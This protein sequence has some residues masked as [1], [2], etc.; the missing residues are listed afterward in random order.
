MKTV[1]PIKTIDREIKK[2]IQAVEQEIPPE[3][4]AAFLEKLN[5]TVPEIIHFRRRQ[6]IYYGALVTA[7]TVLL[8]ILLFLF[9]LFHRELN[10]I[11]AGEIWVQDAR[12][13]GHP[14]ST[15]VINPKDQAVTIVWLEKIN[16]KTEENN[17][18]N[19]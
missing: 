17:E 19:H 15:F 7:A 12:V 14:A 3:L 2:R 6:L 1:K 5:G 13:E 16:H 10:V 11:E 8:V 9:P 18:K 4:E